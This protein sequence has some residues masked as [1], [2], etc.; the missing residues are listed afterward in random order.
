MDNP[1]LKLRGNSGIGVDSL[2][3]ISNTVTLTLLAGS[4]IGKASII[5]GNG[6]SSINTAG[7]LTL[8]NDASL[9][10]VVGDSYDSSSPLI[11]TPSASINKGACVYVYNASEIKD[12]TVVI[13]TT[14]SVVPSGYE[15]TAK[16]DN[17]LKVIR[18]NQIRT[19]DASEALGEDVLASSVFSNAI[20]T[21]GIA[22]NRVASITNSSDTYIAVKAL[23]N[24]ALMGTASGAQTA[25]INAANIQLDV[26]DSHGSVLA[27]YAHEKPVQTFGLT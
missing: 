4:E 10:I 14:D 5:V 23:N 1:S 7:T 18:N 15:I 19:L 6:P 3:S 9:A 12:G 20:N 11:T 13:N 2:K 17:L 27:G 22:K 8:L 24:I 21:E 25:A 26:I 16:T